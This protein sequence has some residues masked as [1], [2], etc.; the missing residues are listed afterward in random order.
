MSATRKREDVE[1]GPS[2]D[3]KSCGLFMWDFP[4]EAGWCRGVVGGTMIAKLRAVTKRGAIS[5][6][7]GLGAQL[8]QD[9]GRAE[10][11]GVR[12]EF[13]GCAQRSRR[14]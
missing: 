2:L 13:G 7:V 11:G 9:G 3:G 12:D 6:V 5:Y 10:M 4:Q 14:R 8:G 1:D